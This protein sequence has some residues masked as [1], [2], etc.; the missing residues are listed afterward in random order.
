[1]QPRRTLRRAIDHRES[2]KIERMGRQRSAIYGFPLAVGQQ[3]VLVHAVPE[4][5]PDGFHVL[6][7]DQITHVRS[8]DCER[9]LE[10]VL[11]DEHR[12]REVWPAR[13]QPLY[14]ELP[15]ENWRTLFEAL[16]ALGEL[17]IVE[18][19]GRR[20]KQDFFSAQSSQWPEMPLVCVT[21]LRQRSWIRRRASC[22]LRQSRGYTLLNGTRVYSPDTLTNRRIANESWRAPRLH[23][24]R[25][26]RGLGERYLT[27]VSGDV[28]KCTLSLSWLTTLSH[29]S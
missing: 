2:V 18:C 26:S 9:F 7:I 11:R 15:L 12:L 24:E 6:P 19:E 29:L 13:G 8:G 17:V 23:N 28:G 10:R 5:D 22:R 16:G 4:F 20:V 3:L 27:E 21:S 25:D 14:A 1:M